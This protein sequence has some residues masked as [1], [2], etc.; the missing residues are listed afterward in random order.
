MLLGCWRV[1]HIIKALI[2]DAKLLSSADWK[3]P[4]PGR[5]RC[6]FLHWMK[7][8][9]RE[10]KVSVSVFVDFWDWLQLCLD[11]IEAK[12]IINL[13]IKNN[14]KKSCWISKIAN[15]ITWATNFIS[16][17]CVDCP[18]LWLRQWVFFWALVQYLVEITFLSLSRSFHDSTLH[19]YEF[20]I[21]TH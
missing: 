10:Q 4:K 8:G 5:F 3:N 15:Q 14:S 7:C 19:F 20:L 2:G 1:M 9:T 16:F 12:C 13:K 18:A 21:T 6:H 11:E 17:R